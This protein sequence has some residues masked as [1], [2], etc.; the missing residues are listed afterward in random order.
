[1]SRVVRFTQRWREL[2]RVALGPVNTYAVAA[3]SV[4]NPP[5]EARA[6]GLGYS[7]AKVRND[8][9]RISAITPRD[10]VV[11]RHCGLGRR[12][13]GTTLGCAFLVALAIHVHRRSDRIRVNRP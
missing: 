2:G 10:G 8:D 9:G 5:D 1:M 7:K 11:N 13:K 4:K 12:A 6:A 3:L